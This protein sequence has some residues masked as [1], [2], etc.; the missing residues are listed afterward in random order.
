M[1]TSFKIGLSGKYEKINVTDFNTFLQ[2]SE[3]WSLFQVEFLPLRQTF[4]ESV[5]HL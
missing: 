4:P 2:L 5:Q 3:D 1:L